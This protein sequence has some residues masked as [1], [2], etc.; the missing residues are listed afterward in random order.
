MHHSQNTVNSFDIEN[1]NYNKKLMALTSSDT[2]KKS[3]NEYLWN[4]VYLEKFTKEQLLFNN[5][6]AQKSHEITLTEETHNIRFHLKKNHY[7]LLSPLGRVKTPSF[8]WQ[9]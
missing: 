1:P 4:S 6:I 8:S 7:C 2:N 9:L 5:Q 3:F